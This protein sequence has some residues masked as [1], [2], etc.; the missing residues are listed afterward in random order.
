VLLALAHGTVLSHW[1]AAR[2][3][4]VHDSRTDR[5]IHILVRGTGGR[6]PAGVCVH[7]TTHLPRNDAR[8]HRGLRVTSS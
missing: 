5:A 8:V 3:W 2:L 4:Q 7:H 6:G 1:T